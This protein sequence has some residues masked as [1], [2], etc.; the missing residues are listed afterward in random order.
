M[1]ESDFFMLTAFKN[2]EVQIMTQI[3]GQTKN[4]GGRPAKSIKR[5]QVVTLKCASYEQTRIGANAKKA[6]LSVSAFLREMGLNGQVVTTEKALPA[7][8][9]SLTG[10]LNHMAANLNQIA[11]KRN[12]VVEELNATER[13]MLDV[14]SKEVKEVAQLIKAHLQ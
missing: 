14:L 8:V 12:S 11:K 13:A 5:N 4:K 10:T 2:Q 7:E 1:K 3:K 6:G 9:L